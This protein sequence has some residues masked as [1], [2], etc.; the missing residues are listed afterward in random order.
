MTDDGGQ[1]T[2]DGGQRIE[3]IGGQ[4]NSSRRSTGDR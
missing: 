2:D 4:M 3:E 1:M